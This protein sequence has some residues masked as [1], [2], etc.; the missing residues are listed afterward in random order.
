MTLAPAYGDGW[1][2]LGHA[3]DVMGR[4]AEAVA[5]YEEALVHAPDHF[6]A[7][8]GKAAAQFTLRD[9]DGALGKPRIVR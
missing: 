1:F 9:Y 6:D 8:C 5:S 2:N 7:W 3:L 4:P